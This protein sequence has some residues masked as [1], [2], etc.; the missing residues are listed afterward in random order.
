MLK[1]REKRSTKGVILSAAKDHP[2]EAEITQIT[3]KIVTRTIR[4]A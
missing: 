2:I 4:S 3:F 1:M